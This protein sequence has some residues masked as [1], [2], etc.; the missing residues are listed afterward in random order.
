LGFKLIFFD[1]QLVL[2]PG[3]NSSITTTPP[4]TYTISGTYQPLDALTSLNGTSPNGTWILTVY[5]VATGDGGAIEGWG[6]EIS[7][8]AI[9]TTYYADKDGDGYGDPLASVEL[10]CTPTTGFVPDNT[11]CDDTDPDINPGATEVCDGLDNNCNGQIDEGNTCCPTGGIL[12]VNH[13]ATGSI[14]G[15]SWADAFT[16]LQSALNSTCPDITQIW[17]AA[18]TYKPTSGTDRTISFHMKDGVAIY[19]G[20][21][22]T[23]TLLSQRDWQTNVTTLS[24]D[25]GTIDDNTDNSNSVVLA[26]GG[27]GASAILDGFT[28]TGAEGGTFSGGIAVGGASPVISNCLITGNSSNYCGGGLMSYAASPVVSNCIFLENYSTNFGGGIFNAFGGEPF[29][30]NCSFINNQAAFTGGGGIY[31]QDVV[32]TITNCTFS[33]NSGE[34]LHCNTAANVSNCIFWGNTD[35]VYNATVAIENCIVQGGYSQCIDCPGGDGNVDPL[36]VDLAN[37]DLRLQP[38][39]PAINAGTNTGAPA[40]DLDGNARPFNP[41]SFG[42]A[43]VDMGAYEYSSPVDFCNT[44]EVVALAGSLSKNPDS[45]GVCVGSNVSATLIPGSGGNGVDSLA[46]RTKTGSST[47][48]AWSDYAS[49]TNI[50]TT[51][52]TA[53]EVHTLRKSFCTNSDLAMVSWMVEQTPAPGTLAKSPDQAIVCKG[54]NVS[55][56]LTAGNGGNGVDENEYRTNDGSGWTD[57]VDYTPATDISTSGLSQVEIRTRRMSDYCEPSAYSTVSW[58]TQALPV[59]QAGADAA[60]AEYETYLLQNA[61]AEN[62][63][64]LEWSTSG[65]G[66]FDDAT[67]LNAVYTPG[68]LDISAGQAELCLEAIPESPCL[69][70]D[71]DCML[72]TVMRRPTLVIT[73]PADLDL[74]YSNPSMM[75]G[76]AGDADNDLNLVE[77]NV[78][79]GGWLTATGTSNWTINLDLSIGLNTIEA[80]AKDDYGLYSDI[81]EIEVTLSG[82]VITIPQGW[83]AISSYLTPHN[84][85][86]EILLQEVN[87]PGSIT[88]MLGKNGIFWPEPGVNTIGDWNVFEGYKVKYQNA[89][90]LTVYG[91]QLNDNSITLGA[92]FQIIPVLSNVP[93][94]ISAI[95]TN[96]VSD[97]KYI[98]DID[99]GLIYWP[100]GG[101]STL[102]TLIP[103]K[104][105]IANFNRSVTLNFPDYSAL[106]TGIIPDN[107]EPGMNGPWALT[108]TGDVHFVAV[109]SEAVNKIEN[110]DFIGAFDSFGNC[111]GYV[112]VDGRGENYLL[113]VY[114]NDATTDAKDGAAQ[115]EPIS[116]RSFNSFTNTETELIAGFDTNF[117]DSDGVYISGGQ[118][119]IISF[120]ESSTGIGEA[121]LAGKVQIYPNP[122]KDVVNIETKGFRT[123]Q[124]F[125][126][127][128]TTDGK[129]V[130]TFTITGNQTQCNVHDLQPGVY[131]LR[132]EN[133]ENVVVKRLVIQ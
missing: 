97:V 86:L 74:L 13:N 124:G 65:N 38:C 107:T 34:A 100:L 60:I 18:G 84:P 90:E 95:F 110:A 127:L 123:L 50:P 21:A 63:S 47:W 111:I 22:G 94:P 105:Y 25:I 131:M 10:G 115:S 55:A 36:F 122:A 79:G 103:G 19:G 118:S 104:G 53:V 73:S 48:S 27:I 3:C 68:N 119:A 49:G 82:Q 9:T 113:S 101:I 109:S 54:E 28:V 16:N 87:I 125:G 24:G 133:A 45:E 31:H 37:G 80:R 51:G 7:T 112:E 96:P 20:F 88:I 61:S 93:S 15:S 75:A 108:R 62:Y 57:W 40:T 120:K 17:V 26:D 98:F 12:F 121:G 6:L 72:L 33:G 126:T 70:S 81:E 92:G 132:I 14:N 46:Y 43:V 35:F 67:N 32:M 2:I 66:T 77:V 129:L 58:N 114:G 64:N 41:Y 44:C 5:D 8:P 30:T 56:T 23:E 85:A 128:M 29:V 83:S 91:D 99:N 59:A 4:H 1:Q 42:S 102:T 71:S 11:D 117:P 116:F 78:N 106:K 69:V 52:K 76:T 89:V 39:S 130:K